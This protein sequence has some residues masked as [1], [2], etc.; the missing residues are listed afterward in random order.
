MKH[1]ELL[2]SLSLF[3]FTRPHQL[4]QRNPTPSR[5]YEAAAS[6]NEGLAMCFLTGTP[7]CAR[8]GSTSQ[9]A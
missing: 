3:F 1:S 2:F 8:L 4:R 5:V 9:K 7:A 6:N